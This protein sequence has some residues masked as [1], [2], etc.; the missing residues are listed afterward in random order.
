MTDARYIFEFF[1][2]RHA[3]HVLIQASERA[4][5]ALV[6]QRAKA[7]FAFEGEYA[8]HVVEN[9]RDLLVYHI[10]PQKNIGAINVPIV[11]EELSRLNVNCDLRAI[12][13]PPYA[14]GL[15]G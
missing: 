13:I 4:G 7:V 8:R 3:G 15:H 1:L 11:F 2:A 14:H 5:G 12:A 9:F 6:S 10:D